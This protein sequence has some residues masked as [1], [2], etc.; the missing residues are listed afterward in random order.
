M[1]ADANA[2]CSPKPTQSIALPVLPSVAPKARNAWQPGH[3]KIKHSKVGKWRAIV[4]ILVH[5][6]IAAHIAHWL[7]TGSTVTPI[8]PSESM[9][10]LRDGVVNAGFIFF[11]LAI[12]S[13]LILGRFFCGWGCHVVALQDL[14]SWIMAKLRVKPKPFRSRLLIYIP[15]GMA[16]YMFVWPVIHREII[17]PIFAD[18]R[19]RLP[20]WLGQSNPIPGLSTHLVT[21]DFWATFPPWYVAIPFFAVCGFA[22]VYFLG[23]KGFCTYGCPYGGFFGPADLLSVGKIKVNDNCHQCGHCTAVCTS[24]VRVHEEVRDYGKV[25][26]PGCMKCLDCVSVCPNGALSFGISTPTVLTRPKNDDAKARAAKAKALREARYDLSKPE[27]L[28]F[29]VLWIVLFWCFRGMLNQVPMLMAIGMAGCVM[30]LTYKSWRMLRDPNSR[31]QSLQLKLKGSIKPA[32]WAV[33]VL[34][35][36]SLAAAAWS[37]TVRGHL[38]LAEMQYAKLSTPIG[39]VFSPTFAPSPSETAAARAGLRHYTLAGPAPQGFGWTLR[40]DDRLNMAYMHVLVGDLAAAEADILAIIDRGN[41]EDA[42]LYQ[43]A[44]IM[45]VRGKSQNDIAAVFRTALEK[46]PDL[47]QI[48]AS[49]AKL[50]ADGPKGNLSG[51]RLGAIALW[52]PLLN[53]KKFAS[54]PKAYLG[55]AQSMLQLGERTRAGILA[56][57]AAAMKSATPDQRLTAAGILAQ[58]DEST[59]AAQLAEAAANDSR[60]TS[61]GST[62]VAAANQLAMLSRADLAYSQAKQAAADAK[63]HGRH[64][65]KADTLFN[66]GVI[67]V[68]LGKPDEG[69]AMIRDAATIMRGTTWDAIPIG[70]FMI[71]TGMQRQDAPLVQEG[72]GI[73]DGAAKAAPDNPS[74]LFE[75]AQAS[76]AA[77][78]LDV[79][80]ASMKAAAEIGETSAVLADRYASML[81]QFG[82]PGPATQAEAARWKDIARSRFNAAQKP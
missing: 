68:G 11:A 41:P 48:R 37:G 76:L 2:Q 5:V 15:L 12:V 17:R 73:I 31:L 6:A 43:L 20:T 32:G 14:C 16:I 59:K 45:S 39:A 49:L 30:F 22:I 78:K 71:Q 19:G 21:Q 62:R 36:V 65:G 7:I 56:Q 54:D 51:D 79:A 60:K 50:Q 42:L 38:Y 44:Q 53:D 77:G 64:I 3:D 82:P 8:E 67:L 52:D 75:H 10:T 1:S 55:A 35:L 18:A 47:H 33:I 66:A 27:E 74:I 23:S 69:L 58:V 26:D 13:T 25:V 70:R 61:L 24:N 4:L 28:V 72:W 9:Q 57:Q 34:T 63:G 29:L 46:H 80:L 40:P 81:A